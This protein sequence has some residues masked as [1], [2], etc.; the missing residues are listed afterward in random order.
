MHGSMTVLMCKRGR[1]LA[2]AVAIDGNVDTKEFPVR[3][4]WHPEE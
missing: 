3:A 1:T 2:H 4:W